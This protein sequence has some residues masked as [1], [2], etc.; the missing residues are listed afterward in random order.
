[1]LKDKFSTL[2]AFQPYVKFLTPYKLAIST[3]LM[4]IVISTFL[5]II[6][7]FMQ[8]MVFDTAIPNREIG[9]LFWLT[10]GML[11]LS[12]G[13]FVINKLKYYLLFQ[14]KERIDY[15][16]KSDHYCH[17]MRLPQGWHDKVSIGKILK[18]ME[19]ASVVQ[20]ALNIIAIDLT[21]NLLMVLIYTPFLIVIN[22][23]LAVL[24][25]IV[26][27]VQYFVGRKFVG[28]DRE[29]EDESWKKGT[30]VSTHLNETF[31]G[32]RIV[33][34]FASESFSARR[35]KHL[36]LQAREIGV[37]RILYGISVDFIRFIVANLIANLMLFIA[38]FEMIAGNLTFG[39]FYAFQTLN[40]RFVDALNGLM[41]VYGHV[42]G[43]LNALGR[44]QTVEKLKEEHDDIESDKLLFLEKVD[45]KITFENVFFGYHEGKNVLR[46]FTL[47]VEA[48]QNVALV[49]RS[50][51][52]KTT[53]INLIM[54]FYAVKKGRITI[55]GFDI[56]HIDITSLRDNVGIVLQENYFFE[57]TIRENL[58]FGNKRYTDNNIITALEKA[59]AWEFVSSFDMGINTKLGEDGT[60]LSGG[61]KQRLAIARAFLRNPKILILDEATSALDLETEKKVQESLNL[62]MKNR[63]TIVIAHRLST[64]T[65]AD[66]ICV[67]DEGM[68]AE[69]GTHQELLS[70]NG[71]YAGLYNKMGWLNV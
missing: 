69:E 7:P 28:K 60:K 39:E 19:D 8:R 47:K 42:V 25:L 40:G 62:L 9:F 16:I 59:N 5:N 66:K 54:K 18:S 23:K 71:I 50:G 53:I 68:L 11:L 34:S 37:K 55:D 58:T 12:V 15:K 46:N 57:G 31:L 49:G 52:G 26:F 1:M 4:L 13:L 21:Q 14:I 30:Q 41:S 3:V 48:G 33:K 27:P 32:I 65:G 20:G 44:F 6:P 51:A 2:Q 70:L 35:F 63:S 24:Q 67:I 56:R 36:V 17:I 61:Q 64:I 29:L 45:G 43:S 22:W 10:T 38:G